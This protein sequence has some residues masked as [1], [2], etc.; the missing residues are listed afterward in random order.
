MKKSI[1]WLLAIL[2]LVLLPQFALA[3]AVNDGIT[4]TAALNVRATPSTNGTILYSVPAVTAGLVL[5]GPVIANGFTWWRTSWGTN[6][7]QPGWCAD[8]NFVSQP[9]NSTVYTDFLFPGWHHRNWTDTTVNYNSPTKNSGN[10]GIQV[11]TTSTWKRMYIETTAGFNTGTQQKTLRLSLM[12]PTAGNEQKLYISLY[13][14]SSQ[15]IHYVEAWD[16]VF[17]NLLQPGVWYNIIIPIA[18]LQATSQAIGGVVVESGVAGTFYVDDISF[19]TS[20]GT[21]LW[22]PT[23]T[24]ITATCNPASIIDNQTSQCTTTVQGT[25]NFNPAV[26]W[27]TSNGTINS[28]GLYTAPGTITFQV[29]VPVTATSVQDTFQ[30]GSFFLTVFP[31]TLA[32]ASTTT[33]LDTLGTGWIMGTWNQVTTDL[34]S[35][36]VYRGTYGV[37]V[38]IATPAWGRVKFRTQTNYKFNTT[39]YDGVSIVLNIGMFE[40]ERLFIAL[41]DANGTGIQYVELADYTPSQTL[42]NSYAYRYQPIRIPLTALGAAN[43]NVYGV[44]IQSATPAT[45]FLDD[46]KFQPTGGCNGQ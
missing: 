10:A 17:G 12:N 33:F 13:D 15:S 7:T 24:S 27:G 39:G 25:G 38:N 43:T 45:F 16:Y 8:I 36:T 14:P 40:D 5:E 28:N 9:A 42:D 21:T 41:L 18:D 31:A 19:S 37:R 11:T 44:E 30:S 1:Q 46:I 29:Q 2:L 35:D 20:P 26:T 3:I 32:Q 23:I 34:E 22:P 4:S 6:P